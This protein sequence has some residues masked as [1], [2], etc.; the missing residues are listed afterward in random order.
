MEVSTTKVIR[1]IIDLDKQASG[2]IQNAK[3]KA[4]EIASETKTEIRE[5]RNETLNQVKE[6]NR[7]NYDSEIEKAKSER[8][9]TLDNTENDMSQL[10]ELYESNK[11]DFADK[12][13]QMLLQQ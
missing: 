8:Q 3:R 12:V 7:Q 4:E 13:L 2:I 6:I 5:T 10:K 11:N 1:R 9:A